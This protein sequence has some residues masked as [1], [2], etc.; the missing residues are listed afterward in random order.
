MAAKI[1]YPRNKRRTVSESGN[2]NTT[3]PTASTGSDSSSI[4]VKPL[5][6]NL[7]EQDD[8]ASPSA[9]LWTWDTDSI[10]EQDSAETSLPAPSTIR[11]DFGGRSFYE[12]CFVERFVELSTSRREGTGP[13][14]PKS[15]IFTL[16]KMLSEAQN[17]SM[18]YPILAASLIYFA[19]VQHNKSAEL[20]AVR[21]YLAGLESHRS[22]IQRSTNS[23][24]LLPSAFDQQKICVPMLFLYF[25]TMRGTTSM[26]WAHHIAA[27]VNG[28]E[29]RSPRDY[30]EGDGH[31][32][33]RSLRSYA[34]RAGSKE[35]Y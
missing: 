2:N 26:A 12:Q 19:V 31:V 18:R 30:R 10:S 7:E 29:G 20:E 9:S 22:A 13:D 21:W 24:E 1:K 6:T 34:V 25:E 3:T 5:G 28:L 17:P 23:R 16:P 27:A 11:D 14:R 33:F 35:R 4:Y 8:L 32:I 15:W